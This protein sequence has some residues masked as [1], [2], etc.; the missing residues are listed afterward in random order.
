[1]VRVPGE[2]TLHERPQAGRLTARAGRHANHFTRG[3]ALLVGK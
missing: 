2:R 3:L 1:M